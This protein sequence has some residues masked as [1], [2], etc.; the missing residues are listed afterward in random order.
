M[1]PP[2]QPLLLAT[3]PYLATMVLPLYLADPIIELPHCLPD[4]ESVRLEIAL[5]SRSTDNDAASALLD[6]AQSRK[7]VPRRR[8]GPCVCCGAIKSPQ[9]RC[10]RSGASLCNACGLRYA[11]R[12]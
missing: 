1:L 4:S 10:N 8:R 5:D 2:I 12:K 3:A 7:P 6:L 11:K 9:W